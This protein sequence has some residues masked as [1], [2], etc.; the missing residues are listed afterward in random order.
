MGEGVRLKNQTNIENQHNQQSN[1]SQQPQ[2]I[3]STEK[4]LKATYT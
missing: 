4:L 2:Q 3:N 1:Q